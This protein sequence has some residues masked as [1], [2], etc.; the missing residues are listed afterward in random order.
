MFDVRGNCSFSH[1]NE[2]IEYY[3]IKMAATI[4]T[5]NGNIN[6]HIFFYQKSQ[7]C[8]RWMIQTQGILLFS[9]HVPFLDID[10]FS[11]NIMIRGVSISFQP[12]RTDPP[13]SDD[14]IL[15]HTFTCKTNCLSN[16]KRQKLTKLA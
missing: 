13:S 7:M 3:N 10:R 6:K 14:N 15:M 8:L 2:I 1:I 16:N 5:Y 4:G 11:K 12:Y 9:C